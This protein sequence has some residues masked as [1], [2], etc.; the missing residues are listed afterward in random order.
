MTELLAVIDKQVMSQVSIEEITE[1]CESKI[2]LKHAMFR[3]SSTL[4]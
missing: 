2:L 4:R 1:L 3:E